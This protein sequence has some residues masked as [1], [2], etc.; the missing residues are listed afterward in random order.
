MKNT[1]VICLAL[2]AAAIVPQ[3]D[4][5][6]SASV[7]GHAT[8]LASASPLLLRHPE[9]PVDADDDDD[10][11]LEQVKEEKVSSLS[12]AA[13]WTNAYVPSAPDTCNGTIAGFSE[14]PLSDADCLVLF[15]V[16]LENGTKKARFG[17]FKCASEIM[18]D[19]FTMPYITC[20][21]ANDASTDLFSCLMET[22]FALQVEQSSPLAN[23]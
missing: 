6:P 4:A 12:L 2:T 17:C 20:F 14:N 10:E 15:K 7:A 18:V 19:L 3:V 23:S 13:V 16:P 11:V 9:E 5:H 8:T 21:L 1:I 22:D